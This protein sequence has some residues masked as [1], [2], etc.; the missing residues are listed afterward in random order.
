[1][2][3]VPLVAQMMPVIPTVAA[4]D[5]RQALATVS[6]VA[7]F[8]KRLESSCPLLG[9]Y[10]PVDLSCRC[11]CGSLISDLKQSINQYFSHDKD[12]VVNGTT[13]KKTRM[14]TTRPLLAS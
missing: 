6:V 5:T 12:E 1:M 14:H 4:W 3:V 9:E 10:L 13:G 7:R 8:R 11:T 2:M